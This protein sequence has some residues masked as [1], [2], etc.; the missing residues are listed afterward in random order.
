ML[1]EKT[2]FYYKNGYNCAESLLRG[3]ND[4]YALGLDENALKVIAG[5]GGGMQTGDVCGALAGCIAVISSRCVQTKAHDTPS[6]KPMIQ[7]FIQRF[8]Q[9]FRSIRCHAIKPLHFHPQQRCLHTVFVAS[10]LL[11]AFI[12][13]W[14]ET[15]TLF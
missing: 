6:L 15:E 7:Q 11:E 1:K 14:D 3:A 12:R 13:E 8:E 10:D 2:S 9:E 5:F 4:A